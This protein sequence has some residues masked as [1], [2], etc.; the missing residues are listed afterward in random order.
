MEPT[1]G[2]PSAKIITA[3]IIGLLVGFAAGVFWQARRF[4]TSAPDTTAAVLESTGMGNAVLDASAKK[5]PAGEA[6]AA[7]TPVS[8]VVTPVIS[9]SA[10][11][12]KVVD[13]PAGDSAAVSVMGVT[14]PVW[15]AVREMKD[16]KVGNILG[17]HKVFTGENNSVIELLR[18]TVA[19]ATYTIVLYKDIGDPAFNYREDVLVEG[20]GGTF[21][22]K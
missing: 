2:N 8:S 11:T 15:A 7:A 9:P 1:N 21:S 22:A 10:L 16:G 5:E 3:L 6:K 14:E 4:P 13:Q 12:L 17:A 18:P 19:G 20:V